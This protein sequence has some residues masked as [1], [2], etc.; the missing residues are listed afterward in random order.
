MKKK[1]YLW[2]FFFFA[3][4]AFFCGTTYSINSMPDGCLF[5][6]Q[7]VVIL[8]LYVL[9]IANYSILRFD[10]H[11][12]KILH[13]KK[14][15][16]AEYFV[17]KLLVTGRTYFKKY[18]IFISQFTFEKIIGSSFILFST[19]TMI[20]K[21][22]NIGSLFFVFSAW[23]CVIQARFHHSAANNCEV[24]LEPFQVP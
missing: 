12:N 20:G 22:G 18:Y 24:C 9:L 13:T 7:S 5:Y 8:S 6:N 3:S 14:I 1:N 15:N 21:T 17:T 4:L 10:G 2:G 11:K 19:E 23:F 16:N